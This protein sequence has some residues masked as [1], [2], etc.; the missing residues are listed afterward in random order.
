MVCMIGFGLGILSTIVTLGIVA[1][2][3]VRWMMKRKK[4]ALM[5]DVSSKVGAFMGNQ[6]EI[7]D[8]EGGK[9]GIRKDSEEEESNSRSSD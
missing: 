3:L 9:D 5:E 1:P 6:T 2:L 7:N 8:E 4:S